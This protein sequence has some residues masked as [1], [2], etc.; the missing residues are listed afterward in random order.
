MKMFKRLCAGLLAGMLM[1]S[2]AAAA[3]AAVLQDDRPAVDSDG[4]YTVTFENAALIN[5]NEY[6]LLIAK[7]AEVLPEAGKSPDTFKAPAIDE[8]TLTYIDQTT[9]AGGKVMFTDFIPKSVPNSVILLGGEFN[10]K[11]SP[12]IIGYIDAQGN[13]V[14]FPTI[15][16]TGTLATG[17]QVTMIDE[18]DAQTDLSG[19]ATTTDN[20]NYSLSALVAENAT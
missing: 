17:L 1:V 8:T 10:G 20:A 12:I 11:T 2:S 14:E 13:L 16:S 19:D 7:T 5:G 4:Q 6:V 15:V 3:D 18:N 9:A